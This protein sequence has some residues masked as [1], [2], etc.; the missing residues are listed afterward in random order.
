MTT[1]SDPAPLE[2]ICGVYRGGNSNILI[3]VVKRGVYHEEVLGNSVVFIEKER[4]ERGHSGL[5]CGPRVSCHQDVLV[6]SL[7]PHLSPSGQCRP[8]IVG[9]QSPVTESPQLGGGVIV[10]PVHCTSVYEG[11]VNIHL[12][13][14]VVLSTDWFGSGECEAFS[15]GEEIVLRNINI[16]A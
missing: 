7:Q 8:E 5:D 3:L 12:L 13:P 6:S 2:D 11:A 15:L 16:E 9:L 1:R 10:R 4:V 14:R